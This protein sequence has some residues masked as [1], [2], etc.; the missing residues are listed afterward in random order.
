MHWDFEVFWTYLFDRNIATAAVITL[1]VA[2]VAQG[3]ATLIGFAISLLLFGNPILQALARIYI[4]AFRGIP[5]LVLLLLHVFLAC[6]N[7]GCGFPFWKPA[8]QACRSMPPPIW[9]RF[10]GRRF[11]RSIQARG[12]QLGRSAIRVSR[13]CARSCLPQALKIILPPFAMNLPHDEN[14][15]TPI[16]DLI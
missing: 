6:P 1:S 2:T 11:G 7:L 14:H 12:K 3:L 10:S 5:P 9:R 4:F 8:S 16:G 15:I 13:R